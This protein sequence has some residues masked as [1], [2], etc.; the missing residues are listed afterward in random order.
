MTIS[1]VAPSNSYDAHK[2]R[3]FARK[4]ASHDLPQAA[5]D[6][7]KSIELAELR[8]KGTHIALERQERLVPPNRQEELSL[9]MRER[10][11]QRAKRSLHFRGRGALMR[12]EG[13]LLARVLDI[14]DLARDAMSSQDFGEFRA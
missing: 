2:G 13:R 3:Q 8:D 1:S 4:P 14:R 5:W 12:C 9:K 10:R 11:F 6:T 7:S